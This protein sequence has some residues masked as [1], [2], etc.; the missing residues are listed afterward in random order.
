MHGG[1]AIAGASLTEKQYSSEEIGATGEAANGRHE[2]NRLRQLSR[3]KRDR[4]HPGYHSHQYDQTSAP[5]LKAA[6]RQI[7]HN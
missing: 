4:Y 6:R 5:K 1:A 3:A 2:S 7:G